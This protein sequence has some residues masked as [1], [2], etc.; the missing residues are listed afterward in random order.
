MLYFPTWKRLLVIGLCLLGI[1][2]SAPNLFYEQ[3]DSYNRAPGEIERLEAKGNEVPQAL[4]DAAESWPGW[5]PSDVVNLGLD[6]RGGA[7][8]LIEVQIG[9][10]VAEHLL[11]LRE[12][13]RNALSE[14]GVRRYTAKADKDSVIF[15]ITNAED[16]A[17]AGE[18]LRGMAQP[19]SGFL[20]S[21][22]GGGADN[23]VI[24]DIGDQS[25][26]VA[27]SEAEVA[28]LTDRTLPVRARGAA[29]VAEAAQVGPLLLAE[30]AVAGYVE[31][32]GPPSKG[33]F[34]VDTHARERS[35]SA[36]AEVMIHEVVA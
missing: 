27:L 13:G 8:V 26:Q 22:F 29:L 4:R 32:A 30:V 34:V 7:H 9:E 36:G 31:A 33:I 17:K 20:G 16:V 28:Q 6:L 12:D 10:V 24:T 18:I 21:G 14:G 15:R 2:F 1:L 23:L 3:A 11:T 19:V 25:F 35:G 5:L